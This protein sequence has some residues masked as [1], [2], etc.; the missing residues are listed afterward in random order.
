M[1]KCAAGERRA[2]LVSHP[3]RIGI[4]GRNWAFLDMERAAKITGARFAVY[5]GGGAKLERALSSFML[6]LHTKEHRYKIVLPPVLINSN[7]LYGTGN[8]PKFADDLFKIEKTDFWLAPTAEVPVTNLFSNETLNAD[9]L[10]I[11][12]VAHTYC[13]R[14]GAGLSGATCAAL[15]ASTSFR[16]L[17]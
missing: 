12:F 16:R 7:S 14:G 4:W 2:S 6:D 17:N 9:E 1:W 5:W 15:S 8:L 13:F 11:S 3:S 10:P